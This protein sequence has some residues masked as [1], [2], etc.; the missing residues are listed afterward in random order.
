MKASLTK[1]PS[2]ISTACIG[3]TPPPVLTTQLLLLFLLI[4]VARMDF[5]GRF[6]HQTYVFFVFLIAMCP[7]LRSFPYFTLLAIVGELNTLRISLYR[8]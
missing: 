1:K 6:A 8:K 3:Y 7:S 2:E 5:S 4:L